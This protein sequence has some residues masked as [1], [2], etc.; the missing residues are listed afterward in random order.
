VEADR[1]NVINQSDNGAKEDAVEAI[2]K[3]AGSNITNAILCTSNGSNHKRVDDFTLFN[4]MQVA[5]DGA[6]HLSTN[7]VLE[8]LLKVI[9]HTFDLC[10]KISINMELL[11]LNAAQ[12]ATYGITI[13]VPQLLLTL[14]ANIESATKSEYGHKFCWAMHAIYKYSY[15]HIHDTASLLTI[16]ME[17]AG[18]DGVRVVKDAPAPGA[19][20][21]TQC[22]F[23]M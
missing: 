6:N 7:D 23:F 12:V 16:L 4:V 9:N 3:L 17:L 2:T 21:P 20:T 13:G 14:L 22:R 10:K 5:I 11:Q 1:L 18:A 8:Q 15:N 19:G